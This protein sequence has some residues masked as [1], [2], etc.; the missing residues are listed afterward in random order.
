MSILFPIML[1]VVLVAVI[2]SLGREG[3]WSNLITLFNMILAAMLATNFYDTAAA[4]LVKSVPSAAYFADFACIWLIFALALAVFQTATQQ[5]SK[6]R[7]KFVKQL[8]AAGSWILA[9]WTGWV[10]VCFFTMTLHMAPLAREF[11]W[12]GFTPELRMYMG[13]AP[14]RKWLGLIHKLSQEGFCRLASKEELPKY[15]FDP[16]ARFIPMWAARRQRYADAQGV[17]PK[18]DGL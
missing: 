10:L 8:D 11:M 7:V 2:A 1:T 3:L 4:A 14:D 13:L 15:T 6:V 18:D 16:E 12:H 17:F 9:V 5:V